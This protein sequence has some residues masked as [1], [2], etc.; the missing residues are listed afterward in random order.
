MNIGEPD[1]ELRLG[2]LDDGL[3]R[4]ELPRFLG[5]FDGARRFTA[6]PASYQPRVLFTIFT[7]DSITG[8]SMRTP[9]TVAS[10]AP[11]LKPKRLM[12]AAGW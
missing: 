11:E 10:A 3:S 7:T 8:T 4:P 5:R 6:G 2:R 12:A 1:A 9:T